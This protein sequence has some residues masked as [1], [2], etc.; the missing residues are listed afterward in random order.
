MPL[1]HPSVYDVK[2]FIC[3]CYEKKRR[4]AEGCVNL[5]RQCPA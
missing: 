2:T 5:P 1:N 3:S 4:W